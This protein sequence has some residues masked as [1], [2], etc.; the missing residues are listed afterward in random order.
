MGRSPLREMFLE[1]GFFAN[2]TTLQLK[3]KG[4]EMATK[5]SNGNKTPVSPKQDSGHP[6]SRNYSESP[7]RGMANDSGT[8][9]SKKVTIPPPPP[10]P[11]R[12]K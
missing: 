7:G 12:K 8:L 9:V 10:P 2:T 3:Q 11:P 5:N 4:I 1:S 6:N